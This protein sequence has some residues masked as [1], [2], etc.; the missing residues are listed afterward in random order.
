MTLGLAFGATLLVALLIS[1]RAHRTVLSGA[2]LFLVA[3]F[4]AGPGVMGWVSVHADDDIVSRM[5]TFA[6]FAVLF[7]DGMR[8]SVRE[9][10][11]AWK[12][13]GRALLL[14]MPLTMLL[15][16]VAARYAC[17][18]PWILAFLTAAALSPT[19]PV[20]ASA[21][22]GREAL[23][24]RLRHL[25]NVE[26]GINDGV[27]LPLVLILLASARNEPQSI[28]RLLAELGMG[29][30]V[31]VVIPAVAILLR[32]LP[33]FGLTEALQ[34]LYLFSVGLLVLMIAEMEHVNEYLAAF[35]AGVTVVSMAP[36]MKEEFHKF[37]ELIAELLKLVALL[38]FGMLLSPGLASFGGWAGIVFALLVVFVTRPLP[39]MLVLAKS[40]MRWAERMTAAW[41]GPKGFASVVYGL[42][43][44]ERGIEGGV[45]V[46]HL[47][48]LTIAISI[49]LHSSTDVPI[50]KWFERRVTR[51][52]AASL[53]AEE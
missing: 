31:G 42:L 40:E 23:P 10:G 32:R 46:Y 16:A 27:A 18:F 48:A 6:L 8:I 50:A 39:L 7:T 35:A 28:G 3:G 14:G 5:A 30:V 24:Q 33:Q 45:A 36:E 25:L 20:F 12:L 19:D 52:E 11:S 4:V 21:I 41:F 26:S 38:L 13:P 29:V 49:I 1:E 51:D 47:I 22:V 43:I 2:V 53:T 17:G 9:L 34:P 15:I 37:G 44:L